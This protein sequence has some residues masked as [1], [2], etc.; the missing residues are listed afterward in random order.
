MLPSHCVLGFIST[1]LKTLSVGDAT[2]WLM[3]GSHK[4]NV[5]RIETVYFH[6]DKV[7]MGKLMYA[8]R[9]LMNNS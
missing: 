4:H 5:E 8:V 9:R 7:K 6:L 1:C 2:I 3:D